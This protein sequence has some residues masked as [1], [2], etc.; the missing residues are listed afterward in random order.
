MWTIRF[1]AS[2]ENL[3]CRVF[4]AFVRMTSNSSGFMRLKNTCERRASFAALHKKGYGPLNE[5]HMR[6]APPAASAVWYATRVAK[7]RAPPG[8]TP[9][10]PV[11]SVFRASLRG[12]HQVCRAG[13]AV[14]EGNRDTTGR[15][16][17]ERRVLPLG[18]STLAIGATDRW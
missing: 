6:A 9:L 10:L 16:V 13:A 14:D 11:D 4:S 7:S 3:T 17:Y 12:C 2:S 5:A 1:A 18:S 8:R 15:I